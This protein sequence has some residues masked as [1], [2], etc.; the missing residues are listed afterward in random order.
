MICFVY[1]SLKKSGAYL[2]VK[3][4]DDFAAVPEALRSM[5]GKLEFVMEVDLAK[6]DKLAHIESRQVRRQLEQQGY[7]LQLPPATVFHDA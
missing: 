2:F 5:I 6:R 1:K 3:Y 7:Y 4:K